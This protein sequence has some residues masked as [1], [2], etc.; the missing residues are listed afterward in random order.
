MECINVNYVNKNSYRYLIMLM[1]NKKA[2]CYTPIRSGKCIGLAISQF[3]HNSTC[4]IKKVSNNKKRKRI[5]S[6][7]LN[8]PID[9]SNSKTNGKRKRDTKGNNE[10][11]SNNNNTNKNRKKAKKNKNNKKKP[12]KRKDEADTVKNTVLAKSNSSKN[13]KQQ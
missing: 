2:H 10:L 12:T 8:K 3:L 5:S 4:T 6:L 7:K 1:L 9:T 11:S 13:T